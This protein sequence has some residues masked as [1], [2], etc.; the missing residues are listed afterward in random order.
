VAGDPIVEHEALFRRESSG[1]DGRTLV[2][3]P[4]S[5]GPWNPNALHGGATAALLMWACETHDPEVAPILT[6]LT[7]ELLRPVPLAALRL[8]TDTLRPG[9]KVQWVTATLTD[10]DD[11]PVAHATALRMRATEVDVS[12]AA[13]GTAEPPPSRHDT[14]LPL[15]PFGEGAIGY[16]SANDVV[17]VRGDWL[18]AGP[19]TAWLRLKCPVV[20]GEPVSPAMRVAAAA[21]FG[22]GVGS[23]VRV[24]SANAINAELTIHLHRHPD[25]TSEWICLESSSW[26]QPTGVGMAETRLHDDQG[27]IG[28]AVQSLLVEPASRLRFGG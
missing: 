24:T 22:S 10:V 2:A 14:P 7:V 6:R 3:T 18:E 1:R 4:L 15:M 16:W 28:R 19:G 9:H 23:A 27:P 8:R 20:A 12:G 5:R 25:P 26:V 13:V 17:L 11:R 21:D